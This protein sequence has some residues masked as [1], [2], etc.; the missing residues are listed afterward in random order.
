MMPQPVGASAGRRLFEENLELIDRISAIVCR[1]NGCYGADAEDFASRVRLKLLAD[2]CAVLGKFRGKSKLSTFLGT[3]IANEFRDRRIERWGKWRPSAMAKRLGL[4]AILLDECLYRDHRSFDEAVLKLRTEHRVSESEAELAELAARLPPHS[5][6]R[7]ESEAELDEL[8]SPSRPDRETLSGE[9]RER[10]EHAELEL[11]AALAE[12]DAED[13]SIL[14]WRFEQGLTV[15]R[16]ATM[17]QTP[18]RPLYTRLGRLL[19]RLRRELERRS[20]GAEEMRQL[21]RE[22]D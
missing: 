11:A 15:A 10:L 12:L 19:E 14:R 22:D 5:A 17:L 6:R 8:Q 21:L 3:V 4:T 13:R 9:R 18:Q 16:I 7:F 20:I 2:D 1:R